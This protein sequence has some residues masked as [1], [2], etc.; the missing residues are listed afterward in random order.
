MCQV[1][2]QN[3]WKHYRKAH[4][5]IC[6]KSGKHVNQAKAEGNKILERW[7][8]HWSKQLV[9]ILFRGVCFNF[10]FI[11]LWNICQFMLLGIEAEQ[12]SVDWKLQPS[13]WGKK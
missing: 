10:C 4:K 3:V 9:F 5:C 8:V 12:K 2:Y 6:V 1:N 7:D 13:L 11:I